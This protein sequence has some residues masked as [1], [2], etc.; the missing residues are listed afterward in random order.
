MELFVNGNFFRNHLFRPD[1]F[2]ELSADIL[3][4]C[5]EETEPLKRRVVRLGRCEEQFDIFPDL[6]NRHM[7]RPEPQDKAEPRQLGFIITPDAAFGAG[8][9]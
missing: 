1:E 3:L 9:E 4:V 6:V 5:F 8:R 2:R 7:R